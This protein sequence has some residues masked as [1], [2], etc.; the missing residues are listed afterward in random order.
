V[1]EQAYLCLSDVCH[2]VEHGKTL[3]ELTA[4]PL[5]SK[6]MMLVR[7][8][9]NFADVLNTRIFKQIS[10]FLRELSNDNEFIKKLDMSEFAPIV[11]N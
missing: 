4:S 10:V 3:Q 9:H 2:F 11:E 6:S 1:I 7:N 8:C 5:V